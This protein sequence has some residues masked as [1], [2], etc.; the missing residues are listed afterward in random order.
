[1]HK[2]KSCKNKSAKINRQIK[3]TQVNKLFHFNQCTPGSE[4]LN[5][6]GSFT[7]LLPFITTLLTTN[8]CCVYCTSP[9]VC[10]Y[11]LTRCSASNL[12]R[13]FN[14]IQLSLFANLTFTY[15]L[16]L[17]TTLLATPYYTFKRSSSRW[18]TLTKS[19]QRDRCKKRK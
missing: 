19:K 6:T 10:G 16:L 9:F 15:Y 14:Y 13:Y 18:Y 7:L 2:N 8:C 12:R 1:M 5:L 17:I 4:P 11:C 3:K